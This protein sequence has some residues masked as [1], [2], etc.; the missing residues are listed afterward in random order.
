MRVRMIGLSILIRKM[1][2]SLSTILLL[3]LVMTAM[4]SLSW[5]ATLP[6]GDLT[7]DARMDI[8]DSLA[9]LQILAGLR[10]SNIA[11]EN[12]A[13]IA[14]LP[15]G[16]G[17][18]TLTDLIVALGLNVD[19]GQFKFLQKEI[20]GIAQKYYN[21][22]VNRIE[23]NL[24][25]DFSKLTALCPKTFDGK[26]QDVSK[27]LF[28]SNVMA[29][30]A[31]ASESRFFGVTLAS[32]A[33]A[34]GID[35]NVIAH[36]LAEAINM[37][38]FVKNSGFDSTELRK[39]AVAVYIYAAFLDPK[40]ADTLI[41]LG[42]IYIDLDRFED[43]R[44]MFEAALDLVPGYIRAR[45]GLAAY[46]L[47]KKDPLKAASMLKND[48][49]LLPG[50]PGKMQKSR[51]DLLDSEKAPDVDLVD[52]TLE[53]AQAAID[54]LSKLAIVSTADVIEAF[55]PVDAQQIRNKINHLPQNDRLILPA[56]T[57]I[58]EVSS[59]EMFYF[60]TDRFAG[61]EEQME[62]FFEPWIRKIGALD[63]K[64]LSDLG[65]QISGSGTVKFPPYLDQAALMQLIP[66]IQE[67][68]A[69]GDFSALINFLSNFDPELANSIGVEDGN[70]T[71]YIRWYNLQVYLKKS[72]A[73]F[74]YFSKLQSKFSEIVMNDKT[75][76]DQK[77]NMLKETEN[78]KIE[79]IM[80]RGL[81]WDVEAKL[82]EKIAIEYGL[83]RNKERENS[84]HN[85]F[86]TM[87]YQYI[88]SFKPMM[89]KM[90]LDT[91]P[92]I[93]LV[94]DQ[95]SKNKYYADLSHNALAF[96]TQFLG[97]VTGSASV[98]GSWDDVT[99]EDLRQVN[100]ELAQVYREKAMAEFQAAQTPPGQE[101]ESLTEALFISQSWG[102]IDLKITPSSIFISG[103][104]L[105][106]AN[107]G[108]N[109]DTD[110]VEGGVGVGIKMS[111]AS[112]GVG[113]SGEL[114]TLLTYKMN[115]TSGQVTEIDWKGTAG[116]SASLAGV[117]VGGNY[118][119]SVMNGNKFSPAVNA[120]YK[121]LN[122]DIFK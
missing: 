38:R 1:V 55:D 20:L 67:G 19:K 89:E 63:Q 4:I 72:K 28:L 16:D 110:I 101:A 8:K 27:A 33:F 47:G 35:K 96:T 2:L 88:H 87:V 10:S 117:T 75:L 50:V 77:I 71:G 49:M 104:A 59:Y 36:N 107:L 6:K 56:I 99:F 24:S 45:E 84:F 118:E 80:A 37:L 46:W 95:K 15:A 25:A 111:A 97:F 39:D 30:S 29:G 93:R 40:N 69:S 68:T 82:C 31:L 5:A 106:A 119:A 79:E 32:I 90:W 85:S 121:N 113:A 34:Q 13:D 11:L 112:Q 22:C 12:M 41:N 61:F 21:T 91:M 120:A 54:Q 76:T 109:W 108:Y 51:Q 64:V 18:L 103:S 57:S 17:Q 65:I 92:H 48:Q 53:T 52:D 60:D 7:G 3:L 26:G 42:N 73:Y 94:T 74:A 43:A 115:L 23:A 98:D 100:E 114:S 86:D 122:A 83:L 66:L 105:I 14:P 70:I 9:L 116:A 44:L 62:G 102:P 58:A 78:Q 81:D